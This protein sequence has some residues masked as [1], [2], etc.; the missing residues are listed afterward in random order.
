MGQDL[1]VLAAMLAAEI[2]VAEVAMMAITTLQKDVMASGLHSFSLK[3]EVS[4]LQ[5]L[6]PVLDYF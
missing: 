2:Q 5:R 6:K 4:S 3:P 1:A